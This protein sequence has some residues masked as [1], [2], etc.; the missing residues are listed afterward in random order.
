MADGNTGIV[1]QYLSTIRSD[2]LERVSQSVGVEFLLHC[3]L[4]NLLLSAHYL[5][6]LSSGFFQTRA[7]VCRKT[8]ANVT[9]VSACTGLQ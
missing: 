6:L 4:P 5:F 2:H 9:N 8:T 3:L 1:G 7:M